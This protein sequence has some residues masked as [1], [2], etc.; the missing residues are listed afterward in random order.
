MRNLID[1]RRSVH[2]TLLWL[3]H[4]HVSP[5]S[6]QPYSAHWCQ[7]SPGGIA[8]RPSVGYGGTTVL[9]GFGLGAE[10]VVTADPFPAFGDTPALA[11]RYAAA[12]ILFPAMA[13]ARPLQLAWEYPM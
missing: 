11:A 2:H 8:A 13:P 12:R 3:P 5:S 10:G 1:V 4:A 7:Y 9:D 6:W